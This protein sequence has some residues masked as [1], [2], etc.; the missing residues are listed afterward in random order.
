MNI[1]AITDFFSKFRRNSEKFGRR[2]SKSTSTILRYI[3]WTTLFAGFS[4]SFIFFMCAS[5][6]AENLQ[7]PA[8]LFTGLTMIVC[9]L[10]CV[11]NTKL[12]D[13]F[14]AQIMSSKR[15]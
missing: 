1:S 10:G 7:L 3:L 11:W 13:E 9:V 8:I 12:P 2:L 4:I 5:T 15:R 6:L 14:E